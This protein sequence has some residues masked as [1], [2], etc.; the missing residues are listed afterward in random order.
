MDRLTRR[1]FLAGGLS[2]S[3]VAAVDRLISAQTPV[4]LPADLSI[5]MVE[6]TMRRVPDA[7]ALG[8]WGYQ[9]AL[10]LYGA[11]LV[12]KRTNDARYLTYIRSWADANVD[13]DG[14]INRQIDALDYMLPGRLMLQLYK[15]TGDQRYATAA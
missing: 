4:A 14:T 15:E 3:A 10:F 13:K 9:Q 6:T 5:A 12:F 7:S 11:F 8:K 1:V 2:V